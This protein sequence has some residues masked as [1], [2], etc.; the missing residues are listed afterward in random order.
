VTV[1]L[2]RS[3]LR[4]PRATLPPST[5]A[6]VCFTQPGSVDLC[7]YRGDS[8]RV[9]VRLTD[10]DGVPIDVSAATWDCDFRTTEDDATVLCSPTIEPVVGVPNA[11]DIVLSAVQSALLDQD[12][13]WDLQMTRAGEVTTVL[14]GKVAVTKDVSRTP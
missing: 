1:V 10:P 5:S 11:V 3:S 8:G 7:V 14:A 6:P 9:R 2:N 12:C 13:V 4:S